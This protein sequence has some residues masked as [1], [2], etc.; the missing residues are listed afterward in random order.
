MLMTFSDLFLFNINV[1]AATLLDSDKENNESNLFG[2][3]RSVIVNNE[4]V[5]FGKPQ[6]KEIQE[7]ELLAMALYKSSPTAQQCD[8]NHAVVILE[9]VLVC[10][11]RSIADIS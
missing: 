4:F 11:N 2:E 10:F 3:E 8:W 1:I 9:S 7:Q 5:K 6:E